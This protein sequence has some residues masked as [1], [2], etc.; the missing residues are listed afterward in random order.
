MRIIETKEVDEVLNQYH[1]A[2][3]SVQCLITSEDI[4]IS[5][6]KKHIEEIDT[7][8]KEK[9]NFSSNYLIQRYKT[10]FSF[11]NITETSKIFHIQG[12]K[13]SSK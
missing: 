3:Q 11:S 7:K 2:V 1:K 10:L 13:T 6:P 8:L 12:S 9:L 4:T 5:V